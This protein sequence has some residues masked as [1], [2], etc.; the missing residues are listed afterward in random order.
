M[1]KYLKFGL[2]FF[3][4]MQLRDFSYSGKSEKFPIF[5]HP[6]LKFFRC[7]NHF[8]SSV[9]RDTV[10]MAAIQPFRP[11]STMDVMFTKTDFFFATHM[12]RL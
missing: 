9:D 12:L 1:G 8:H 4:P 6:D 3:T 10:A 2:F 11:T 5:K 7:V